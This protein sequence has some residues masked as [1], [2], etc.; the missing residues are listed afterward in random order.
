M[1]VTPSLL[2]LTLADDKVSC[3]IFEEQSIFRFMKQRW[4]YYSQDVA[5]L[6]LFS[7]QPVCKWVQLVG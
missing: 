5:L 4:Q 7:F 1:T 2:P 3:K 6:H